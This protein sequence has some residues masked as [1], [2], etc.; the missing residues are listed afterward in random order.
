[1]E[2][3][4]IVFC[5]APTAPRVK[6]L[7]ERPNVALT[8]DTAGAP[9]RALLIRGVASIEIVEGVAP[10]YIAAS[11]KSLS[12]DKLAAFEEHVRGLYALMARITIA[13]TWARYSPKCRVTNLRLRTTYEH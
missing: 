11:A 8:I 12:A 2:R 4:R 5:T 9:A 10:E 13:P 3:D 6:A 7:E 1:L